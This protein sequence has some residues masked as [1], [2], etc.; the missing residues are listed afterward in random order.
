MISSKRIACKISFTSHLGVFKSIN[1]KKVKYRA[2]QRPLARINGVTLKWFNG[3]NST[4]LLIFYDSH[5][6]ILRNTFLSDFQ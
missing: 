1:R 5:G 6:K 3:S 2:S 4:Y